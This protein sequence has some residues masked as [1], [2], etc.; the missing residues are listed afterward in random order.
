M[1]EYF[2]IGK[3]CQSDEDCPEACYT[4]RVRLLIK[5]DFKNFSKFKTFDDIS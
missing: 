2:A 3:P 1:V 4:S 5:A